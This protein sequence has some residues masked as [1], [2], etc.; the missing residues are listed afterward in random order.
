MLDLDGLDKAARRSRD[1]NKNNNLTKYHMARKLGFSSSESVILM[2]HSLETL[3]SLAIK[4]GFLK[5]GEGLPEVTNAG[6]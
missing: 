1:R 3:R 6:S 5:D 4:K 2:G